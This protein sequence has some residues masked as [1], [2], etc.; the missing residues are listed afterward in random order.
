LLATHR[1]VVMGAR[2]SS[3]IMEWMGAMATAGVYNVVLEV[4]L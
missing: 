3:T 2:T 4:R 1:A